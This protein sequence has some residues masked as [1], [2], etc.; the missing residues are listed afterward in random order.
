MA[1]PVRQQYLRMKKQYPDVIALLR[2]GDFYET[3]DDGGEIVSSACSI[4]PT[5]GKW[6]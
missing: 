3:F 1:A 2:L 4:V 6:E 5:S